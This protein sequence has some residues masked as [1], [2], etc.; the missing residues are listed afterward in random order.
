VTGLGGLCRASQACVLRQPCLVAPNP[1]TFLLHSLQGL[2][3]R[4]RVPR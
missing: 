1:L 2:H 4:Y 3:G